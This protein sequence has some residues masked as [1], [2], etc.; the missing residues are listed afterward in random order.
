[1]DSIN[2]SKKINLTGAIL[3]IIS[4][5]VGIGI[6]FKNGSVFKNNDNNPYGVLAS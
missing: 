3:I 4:Q 5:V 2:S 6:F 1:M